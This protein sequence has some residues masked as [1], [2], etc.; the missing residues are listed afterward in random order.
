MAHLRFVGLWALL[1]SCSPTTATLF[2]DIR[3]DL[4]AGVEFTAT[5]VQVFGGGGTLAFADS[6]VSAADDFFAG[7]RVAELAGLPLGTLDLRVELS[8]ATGRA[9]IGRPVRVTLRTDTVVTVLVTRDCRGV[10]CPGAGDPAA[11]ACL[12]GR[13]VDPRCTPEAP[14]RCPVGCSVAADCPAPGAACADAR[15]ES[16]VCFSVGVDARCAA[17]EYCDPDDA[18]RAR[19]P[20]GDAGAASDAGPMGS[21]AGTTCMEVTPASCM[22]TSSVLAT[23]NGSSSVDTVRYTDQWTSSCGSAGAPDHP[24]TLNVL[25]DGTY[26]LDYVGDL[27]AAISIRQDTCTGPELDCGVDRVTITLT[28]G[29]R[30]V[31][32]VETLPAGVCERGQLRWMSL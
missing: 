28:A 17:D 11:T 26:Q 24:T 10:E 14:E 5:R 27:S 31:V 29:E 25:V 12:G 20:T 1:A 6:D 18:C 22:M 23:G 9:V 21:D 15:C 7:V 3:T 4:V 30:I 13:C 2:V 8:D 19:A 16:G 32:I